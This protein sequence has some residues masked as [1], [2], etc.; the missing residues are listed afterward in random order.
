MTEIFHSLTCNIVCP[1]C[2]HEHKADK[3]LWHDSMCCVNCGKPFKFITYLDRKTLEVDKFE[4]RKMNCKVEAENIET[5]FDKNINPCPFCGHT[6]IKFHCIEYSDY[7]LYQ[8][9]CNNCCFHIGIKNS[10]RKVV[11][12]VIK[13]WNNITLRK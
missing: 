5:T 11:N 2:G 6:V 12:E 7:E 9:S 4:T 13:I 8:L 10:E 1:Y 3:T